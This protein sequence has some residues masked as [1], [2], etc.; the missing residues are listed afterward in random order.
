MKQNEQEHGE[1]QETAEQSLPEDASQCMSVSDEEQ[2]DLR[3]AQQKAE[4]YLDLLQRTQADFVNYRRRMSQEQAE[5]RT[6]A[7]VTLLKQLLPILD[8]FERAVA[9]TPAELTNN[10]WVQGLLLIARR[11]TALLDQLCVQQIG[12]AGEPFD[13]RLHEAIAVESVPDAAEGTIVKVILAGYI[14]GERVIR[15]AQVIVAGAS[16]PVSGAS[17][18]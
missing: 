6:N 2:Q 8:D 9:V 14:L 10:S 15:P 1:P 18:E 11:L 7:Q 13:P 5:T 3:E 17:M 16:S 4:T 12:A